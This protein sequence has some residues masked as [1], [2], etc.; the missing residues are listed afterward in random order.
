VGKKGLEY[1][2][3]NVMTENEAYEE[4]ANIVEQNLDMEKIYEII[5]V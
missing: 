5:E 2:P 4:L 3:D 1:R